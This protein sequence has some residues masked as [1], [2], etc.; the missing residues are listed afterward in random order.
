MFAV[1]GLVSLAASCMPLRKPYVEPRLGMVAPVAEEQKAYDPS[2]MIGAAYGISSDKI[3]LEASLDYFHSSEQYIETN[4]L[5]LRANAT[6]P[7]RDIGPAVYLTGGLAVLSEFS[8]I[9]IPAFGVHDEKTDTTVGL[10]IGANMRFDVT[11][12]EDVS[13][14]LNYIFLFGENVKGILDLTVGYR[15]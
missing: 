8:D 15:F 6:Y 2:F 4:S 13:A 10:N 5:L 1:A 14:R 9:D 11:G 12:I 3:G 7:L